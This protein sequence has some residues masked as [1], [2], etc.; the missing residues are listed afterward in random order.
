MRPALLLLAAAA[1]WVLAAAVL[2]GLRYAG[3]LPDGWVS[4]WW[5]AGLLLLLVA[6]VD[7]LRPGPL[8]SVAVHRQLPGS[9]ALGVPS[10]VSMTIANPLSRQLDLYISEAPVAALKIEGMPARLVL[11][12]GTEQTLSYTVT[13]VLRGDLLLARPVARIWSRLR[14]WQHRVRP[15]DELELKI[16]PDF[17]P[18]RYLAEI[19]MEQRMRQLGIHQALARGEG[20]EFKQL[21]NFIEG[22]ALRQVDWKASARHRKPISREY[23]DERDQDI[24]FLLDCGRRMRHKDGELS[25]FDHALNAVLLTSWIA[26]RQGDAVGL[27]SFAGRERW[28][29]PV[30][31]DQGI[32]LLLNRVYDL[33]STPAHSDFIQAAEDFSSRHRKRALVVIV[34][35]VRDEDYGDLLAATKLLSRRHEVVVASMREEFLDQVMAAPVATFDDALGYAATHGYLAERRKVMEQLVVSGVSVIDTLPG[36][37]PIQ[38]ASEYLR[39]K[40]SH[41]L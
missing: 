37:L 6:A 3:Q 22:D 21:R 10:H 7:A 2:A 24:F 13:P 5:I 38:L 12:A 17:A 11:P 19:D 8:A 40:K 16:Y 20:M 29:S 41:R 15:G 25:H 33:Q 31:G 32:K 4:G 39:L 23:Q 35:N 18:V 27:L 14:L 36:S 28:L 26:F 9:L 34:S 30:K 1:T